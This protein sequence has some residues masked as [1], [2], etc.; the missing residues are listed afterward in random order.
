MRQSMRVT[1]SMMRR[2]A[3]RLLAVL[4]LLLFA[5]VALLRV[6]GYDGPAAASWIGT[7]V[8]HKVQ[9]HRGQLVYLVVSNRDTPDLPR[10]LQV[11]WDGRFL[12]PKYARILQPPPYLYRDANLDPGGVDLWMQLEFWQSGGA[13]GV[14]PALDSYGF[15]FAT[16]RV[17]DHPVARITVLGCP[18]WAVALA[19]ACLPAWWAVRFARRVERRTRGQCQACG[20]DLRASP[21]KCPE[22]GT[23]HGVAQP[24]AA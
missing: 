9:S 13:C 24:A 15:I 22:C 3:F 4:S 23:P 14:G 18:H 16:E 7:R 20:Y 2:R 21:E 19:A 10:T 5:A 17:P 11:Y 8:E 1:L 6:K 12:D